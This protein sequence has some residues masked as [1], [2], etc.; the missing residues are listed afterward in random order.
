MATFQDDIASKL[1]HSTDVRIAEAAKR[2]FSSTLPTAVASLAAL[3]SSSPQPSQ[4]LATGPPD[5]TL[6][7]DYGEFEY[8]QTRSTG[9]GVEH[10]Q[11]YS[12]DALN[13]TGGNDEVSDDYEESDK[14]PSS[15]ERL[16]R[17]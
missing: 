12:C 8:D 1:L 17:R 11:N 5:K 13:S 14:K 9:G 2:V 6:I 7:H 15:T 10:F 16:K 4:P 3:S